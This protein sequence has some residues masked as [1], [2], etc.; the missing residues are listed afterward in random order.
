MSA[1]P[2]VEAHPRRLSAR[3]SG[4]VTALL[5][6]ALEVLDEVGFDRLSIRTVARRSGL[7]HTTAYTYFS[8]KDHLV[9]AA[10][11]QLLATVPQPDTPFDPDRPAAER[12][13]D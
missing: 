5:D 10:F 1:E 3:Q 7:T 13:A 2:A 8:S 4:T 12:I 9:A 11:R 6:A